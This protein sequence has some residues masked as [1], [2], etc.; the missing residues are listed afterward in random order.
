MAGLLKCAAKCK[1]VNSFSLSRFLLT[2]SGFNK[3]MWKQSFLIAWRSIMAYNKKTNSIRIGRLFICCMLW[4]QACR[5]LA[6]LHRLS[7]HCQQ[8]PLI[9]CLRV[10]FPECWKRHIKTYRQLRMYSNYRSL[11]FRSSTR[12]V[13]TSLSWIGIKTPLII[14]W[15]EYMYA[16]AREPADERSRN[17][18]W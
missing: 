8:G 15:A 18:V 11:Q 14:K 5:W 13:Q 10:H 4:L 1:A 16:V 17:V 3:S 7:S 6:C 9:H 2:S 12:E